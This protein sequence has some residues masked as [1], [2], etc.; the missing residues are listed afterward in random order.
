M[1]VRVE[2]GHDFHVGIVLALSSLDDLSDL[3]SGFVFYIH[4]SFSLA[5]IFLGEVANLLVNRQES[6]SANAGDGHHWA[7][8]VRNGIILHSVDHPNRHRGVVI[9]KGCNDGTC[10]ATHGRDSVGIQSRHSETH[11]TPVGMPGHVDA[12]GIDREIVVLFEGLHDIINGHLE[13]EWIDSFGLGLHVICQTTAGQ[14]RQIQF[15]TKGGDGWDLL[16]LQKARSAKTSSNDRILSSAGP[17]HDH[18]LFFGLLHPARVRGRT[19]GA[20]PSS[21]NIQDE[22]SLCDLFGTARFRNVRIEAAFNGFCSVF[23]EGNIDAGVGDGFPKGTCQ[24]VWGKATDALLH[25][26]RGHQSMHTAE[27]HATKKEK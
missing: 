22:R 21:V 3:G 5:A 16:A 27:V 17:N 13:K 19:Q 2:E 23:S 6:E 24:D 4:L 14:G 12:I 20:A 11:N 26:F 8:I 7:S 10:V 1:V 18:A 9:R 15:D 25:L